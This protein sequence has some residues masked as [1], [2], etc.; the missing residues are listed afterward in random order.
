MTTVDTVQSWAVFALA[1]AV[2]GLAIMLMLK[3]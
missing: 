3:K 1:L 2:A